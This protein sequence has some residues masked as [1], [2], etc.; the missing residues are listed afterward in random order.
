MVN[1]VKKK[2]L[3]VILARKGSKRIPNK[4]IIDF[5]N[6]PLIAW[7]IEAA[8]KS[9]IFDEIFVSTDS[10]K[11]K[12]IAQYYGAD[13]PFMRDKYFDDK[14]PSSLATFQT[15]KKCKQDLDL[16]FENIFQLL[17]SCPFRDE[18]VIRKTFDFF[19]KN[20]IHSF[21]EK[22]CTIDYSK[23]KK[24]SDIFSKQGLVNQVGYVNRFNDIFITVKS[25]LEKNL[26]GDIISFK[27]EMYSRTITKSEGGKNWRDNRLVGG[28][29]T[30]DMAAHAIDLM[31]YFFHIPKK[32]I[33]SNLIKIYSKNVEDSVNTTFLYENGLCGTLNVNWSDD[34]YRKPTNKIEVFGNQ[35][36]ILADQHSIKLFLKSKPTEYNFQKGWNKV[37]ITDIFNPVP[38]YVRGNE[39]TAQLYS[40]IECIKSNSKSSCTFEDASETLYIINEIFEDYKKNKLQ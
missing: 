4:N 19:Q 23:A 2:N 36:K 6:K 15:I 7:T 33:G 25:Y 1:L 28:G 10:K 29:A 9:K 31:N 26:I 18:K 11:I 34:S 37:Y 24:L 40:F 38:F 32:V 3:A 8:K 35:G 14:S 12:K 17:P 30:F 27:T 5:N 21:V 22:P 39:F 20:K 16:E 13:V